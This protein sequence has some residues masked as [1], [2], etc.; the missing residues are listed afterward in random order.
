MMGTAGRPVVAL[1][2]PVWFPPEVRRTVAAA[3]LEVRAR[4]GVQ[5]MD[6][7]T[8]LYVVCSAYLPKPAPD[9]YFT[10]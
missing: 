8:A 7:A 2:A 3:V 5:D 4:S 10:R 6:V 9:P 1:S